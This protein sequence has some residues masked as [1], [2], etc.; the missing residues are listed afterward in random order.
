MP[1]L[2][3]NDFKK[4]IQIGNLNAVIGSDYSI[5][6]SWM[7]AAEEKAK[8]YLVQK[9]LIDQEF[10][11]TNIWD[12]TKAYNAADRVYLDAPAYNA[13][14]TYTLNTL[15]LQSGNIYQCSTAITVPEVFNASHWILLGAQYTLFYAIYPNP[16]FDVYG[17]Y[18]VSDIIFWKN[19]SYTAKQPTANINNSYVLQ[20]G[21]IQNIP[22]QNYF[23]DSPN[24]SQWVTPTDYSVPA[25]TAI[26]NTT[27]WIQGDN[28]GQQMVQVVINL[29]LYYAHA[30][31]SPMSVPAHIKENYRD[32]IDWLKDAA[33]GIIT[34]NLPKIQPKAGNRIRYG[35]D[36]RRVNSY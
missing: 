27:Y 4:Q 36:I 29:V 6:L 19:S 2:I 8:S 22:L 26:T 23:P 34:P 31:I 18:N 11:N 21:S 30:R 7:L 20:Y 12:R 25:N 9:Y 17:N 15:I 10:T 32:S 3:Q 24:Q 33:D 14:N 16:V 13:A 5:I 1:Y 28:R 35:G